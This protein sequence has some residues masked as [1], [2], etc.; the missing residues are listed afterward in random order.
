MKMKFLN[1][2][3]ALAL[4]PAVLFAQEESESNTQPLELPNMIIIRDANLDVRAGVKQFPQDPRPL[5]AA[6]LD[7][8]NSLEKQQTATLPAEPLPAGRNHEILPNAYFKGSLGRFSTVDIEGGFGFEANGYKFFANA[9]M[10]MSGGHVDNSEYNKI[11]AKATS[12][13]IAPEKYWIFGGSRT[14]LTFGLGHKSYN[15]YSIEEAPQRQVFDMSLRVNTDGNYEGFDFSTGA[16][17]N[18]L[19]MSQ[20]NSDLSGTGIDAFLTVKN[21]QNK[22]ELGGTVD[23]DF[24]SLHSDGISFINALL[25]GQIKMQDYRINLRGGINTG[26][27]TI[28]EARFAPELYAGLDYLLN[29]DFTLRASVRSGLENP[30]F[31]QFIGRNPYMSALTEI[32]LPHTIADISGNLLFHPVKDIGF[33]AEASFRTVSRSP[34]YVPAAEGVFQMA[35]ADI[36]VFE[37]NLEGFYSFSRNKDFVLHPFFF[38][39]FSKSHGVVWRM[40][41]IAHPVSL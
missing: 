20:D 31:M 26:G 35:Y 39:D 34:V 28:D 5:T 27:G 17:F 38:H 4:F 37:L 14:R 13:Y 3:L 30:K 8:L 6:E 25:F 21:L 33:S 24:R 16:G 7:S 36:N 22:Y 15:L 40:E 10:D 29:N 41:E 12:D 9:G 19:Q 32:D 11:F 1:I 2:C 23:I 18:T